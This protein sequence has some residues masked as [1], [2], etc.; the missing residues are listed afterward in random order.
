MIMA[1]ELK[2]NDPE[3]AARYFGDKVEFTTGPVELDRSI[4]QGAD[5]AV[6]DVREEDDYVEGHIPGAVNL[7]RERWST[8]AGLRKDALN[9][10][11]C[12]SHVCHLAATA[13]VEFA[14]KGYSVME[15]DGGFKAWKQHDLE[16]ESRPS[17]GA[18]QR[19]PSFST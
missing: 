9:V 12:Y 4:K 7:P 6:I 17:T 18:R 13:A 16:V 3:K 10:I 19:Q 1:S 5:L 8:Q 15:M 2:K 14:R 11:Y